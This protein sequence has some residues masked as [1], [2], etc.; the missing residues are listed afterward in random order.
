MKPYCFAENKITNS[1][2][3]SIHP[4]DI[5]LIRGYAIFDFFRTVGRHPLFLEEYLE[6]FTQSAEKAGLPLDYS[7]QELRD[8]VYTL[9]E[10]NDHQDG[11]VRM[12]LTGGLSDN[13]FLPAR[14]KLFIFC[15]PLMLP[16]REKYEKGV[17]LLSV[18]YV[19]PL[20]AIKTTNY[21]YPCW[22]SLD[23]KAQGAEDVVYH[24]KDRVSES[25]RSNIFLVKHG[26]IYTPQRDILWGITRNK[27][28]KLAGGVGLSDFNLDD[29]MGADEIFISSTTK[30]I[31]PITDIDNVQIGNGHPGP[32][33]K[34]LM[35]AFLDM[36][37][38]SAGS[39]N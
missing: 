10:K 26:Q 2:E 19:R 22:L 33:T 5:G 38:E 3:A 11:G 24:Y 30:R 35:A 14:G 31:L 37:K 21:T 16:S 23:W 13:H 32:V 12:V 34:E 29:L 36:E 7:L 25:S 28:M 1:N 9:I 15:E 39:V 6:R 8:I 27:V 20:P 17:K 18:E 4:L